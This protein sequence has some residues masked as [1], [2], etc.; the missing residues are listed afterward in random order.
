MS[1]LRFFDDLMHEVIAKDNRLRE[2]RANA[3]R[4]AE[5]CEQERLASLPITTDRIPFSFH[6]ANEGLCAVRIIMGGRHD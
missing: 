6:K 5:R 1:G 2:I 4:Y 3:D